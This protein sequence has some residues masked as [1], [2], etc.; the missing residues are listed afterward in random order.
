MSELHDSTRGPSHALMFQASRE[1]VAEETNQSQARGHS[2]TDDAAARPAE[3][4]F[5]FFFFGFLEANDC[6][7]CLLKQPKN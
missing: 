4:V 1:S 3:I 2:L 6:S 7:S 5:F